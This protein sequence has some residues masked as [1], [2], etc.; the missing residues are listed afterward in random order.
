MLNVAMR[1]SRG[2]MLAGLVAGDQPPMDLGDFT[3][4]R[5]NPITGQSNPLFAA[6][7]NQTPQPRLLEH[8]PPSDA[9]GMPPATPNLDASPPGLPPAN[10]P[11]AGS[12]VTP[13]TAE[14]R[15]YAAMLREALGERPELHGFR[16]VASILAPALAAFSGNQAGANQMI[17][18]FARPGE[19]YD[20]QRREL[21][22]EAVKWGREDDQ[23]AAKRA[24]PRYFSGREDQVRYDPTTGTSERVYDAPQDFEDF[25][26]AGGFKPG[27]P[28][29]FA[30]AEDYV[31]R[32]NGPSAFKQDRDMEVLKNA[33]RITLE[34]ERQRNRTAL[35]GLPNYRDTHPAPPR[36]SAPRSK[37]RPTAT[38]PNGQK[39][40]FDG[41]AWVPAG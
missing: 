9:S 40:E 11:G 28:E 5:R 36:A 16:K 19:E 18:A 10:A 21:G 38:G 25:A 3:P 32:G 23:A 26:T 13:I 22:M 12:D 37:A 29:Y 24:E 20:R 8:T 7:A 14:R 39:L 33:Q 34:A 30:A 2:S 1:P 35:R 41:K 17:A 15:N 31:L 27:T 6:L 4:G